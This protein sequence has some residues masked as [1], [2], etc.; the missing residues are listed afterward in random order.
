M[1]V[2]AVYWKNLN[3]HDAAEL[4]ASIDIPILI[5]HGEKDFQ[6]FMEDYELWKKNYQE[7]RMLHLSYIKTLTIYL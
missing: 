3:S 2:P 4:A 5:L 7:K 1:G 6:V